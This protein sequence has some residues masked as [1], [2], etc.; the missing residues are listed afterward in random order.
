MYQG[1]QI[2][3]AQFHLE[4]IIVL[5]F[6]MHIQFYPSRDETKSHIQLLLM[7]MA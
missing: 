6:I 3:S 7:G 1:H 5:V 4:T 2:L